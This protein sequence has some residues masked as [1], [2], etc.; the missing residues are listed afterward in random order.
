MEEGIEF[1]AVTG[2]GAN[3]GDG[4]ETYGNVNT[5]FNDLV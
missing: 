3:K 4:S 2:K 5:S 1:D